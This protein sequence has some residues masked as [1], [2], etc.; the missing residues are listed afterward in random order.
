MSIWQVVGIFCKAIG[1]MLWQ[2]IES[3]G[4]QKIL[5]L[6][7]EDGEHKRQTDS[8]MLPNQL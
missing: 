3:M 4:L 2:S 5:S 6:H 1:S 7:D 8:Q